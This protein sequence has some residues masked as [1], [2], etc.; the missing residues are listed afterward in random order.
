MATSGN[1]SRLPDF[2]RITKED[3]PQEYRGLI[4]RLALPINSHIEQVRNLFN[5]NIS[6]NNLTQEYVTLTIQT[7][8]EG[9]PINTLK[10]K[11]ELSSVCGI[12]PIS[13]KVTSQTNAFISQAPFITFSQ[14]STIITI[15]N[16]SGLSPETTYEVVLL[17]LS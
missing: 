12:I 9:S 3:F 17:I 15:D 8:S 10:F 2:K 6:I 5:G 13:A 4:E 16:I 1:G 7:N 14:N 11:T